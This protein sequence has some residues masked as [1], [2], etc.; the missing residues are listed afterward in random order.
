MTLP[1][2]FAYRKLRDLYYL[3]L[4]ALFAKTGMTVTINGYAFRFAPTYHR[5]FPAD[6]ESGTFRFMARH[7]KPGMVCADV[8]AHLGLYSILFAKHF[9]CMVYGFEP[10]PF[11]SRMFARHVALNGL[12]SRVLVVAEAVSSAEGTMTFYVQNRQDDVA[13]SL[14]DYH[15]S[16]ERKTPVAVRVTSI[17][18]F[19]TDKKIDFI[20]IDAEGV[21]FDV[22]CGAE[23]TI[24]RCRPIML[25]ALHP[26]AIA[27]KGDSLKAI[28]DILQKQRYI[29]YKDLDVVIGEQEFCG[30]KN[31]FDVFLIPSE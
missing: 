21:E 30:T 28:W 23:R 11:T 5:Y 8:G 3:I 20:K 7:V 22:L 19:F 25:L 17:D 6:Y 14:V 26:P 27:A 10:T 4:N 12:E 2:K 29:A 13:N 16:D 9:G 24:A 31:L 15:H 18:G 1:K